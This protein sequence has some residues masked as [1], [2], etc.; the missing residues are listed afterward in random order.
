[1]VELSELPGIDPEQELPWSLHCFGLLLVV[2][3]DRAR[4][5]AVALDAGPHGVTIADDQIE[6]RL[7]QK[8]EWAARR[9]S[10]S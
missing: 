6:R 1:M 7:A 5:V 10:R 9:R 8:R 3:D 4:I 2:L